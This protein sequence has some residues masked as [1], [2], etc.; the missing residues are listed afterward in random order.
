MEE[1]KLKRINKYLSEVGYCS[2]R[3]A[4]QLIDEGRVT[5][6][7]QVPEMGTKI[8]NDDEVRVNG[9]LIKDTKKKQ[10]YL[11]FNKPVGIVCTTDTKV[12]KDNIIDYIN[13]PTRIFPIGRLDKPS[14]GLILLTDDGDIVNK[15]LRARNNH[16]KEYVVKVDRPINNDFLNR[17]SNGVPILDT[18]TKKCHV[19]KVGSHDFK[20]T[21]TQGLNRQ[22]RRM[23]EYLGFEVVKLKRIRIMNIELDLPI[24]KYRELTED[25]LNQLNSLISDSSKTEEAS[26]PTPTKVVK[27]EIPKFKPKS[28]R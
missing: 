4:D 13:Y 7:G 1:K 10:V 5:I 27:K 15:I 11:A 28:R 19:E 20:I 21:L 14:E 23:C 12:E 26:L 16:E 18:I 2:R 17:M 9:E 3:K 8:S 6:N 22:I 24:G 25:E